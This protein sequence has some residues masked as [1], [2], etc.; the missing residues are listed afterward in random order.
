MCGK[1]SYIS[2]VKPE[3]ET[4][5]QWGNKEHTKGGNKKIDSI[6]KVVEFTTKYKA[7]AKTKHLITKHGRQ[8]SENLLKL[9]KSG[10]NG[11][12]EKDNGFV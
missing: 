7:T 11:L 3:F 6:E 2:F 12:I 8:A 5:L 1:C 9:D 10:I 4:H